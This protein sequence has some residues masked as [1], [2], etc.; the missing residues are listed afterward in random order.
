MS[1][2]PTFDDVFAVMAKAS[3]GDLTARVKV[4]DDARAD[5]V[6]TRFAIALNLLLEDLAFRTA[7]AESAHEAAQ[8][9]LE[10][11]VSERTIELATVNQK[12]SEA[13]RRKSEFL[14]SMSHEL[15]TPLN[16]ILGFADLL[17]ERLVG[18]LDERER[19]YLCNIRDAGR[20]LLGLINDVLD[21]SKVE[22]G[23]VELRPERASLEIIVA[24]LVSSTHADAE[25]SGV[26]FRAEIEGAVEIAADIGRVRQIL[27]NLL[28]N[29]VKFTPRGGEVTLQ[30]GRAGRDLVIR[31]SDTG[32]GIPAAKRQQVF[33]TFERLH[34]GLSDAPGT[35]LGL[36]L[37]KSLVELHGG[38]ITFQST[39][40]K[41]TTFRVL[42]PELVAE[43]MPVDRPSEGK[44]VP[45]AAAA[46]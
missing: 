45:P 30:A 21:L 1:R 12:L 23:R 17:E 34:E 10:G 19:R 39:E 7:E 2:S 28:S 14:A 31:V 13:S 41:G 37:T 5:D 9:E 6:A 26:K 25:S 11:K 22:A 16:A 42:L 40:G 3:V 32:I 15:R 36:A 20:H 18:S 35:G 33:G 29:A 27:Y 46:R 38:A 43:T 24:P 44:E 4:P 8:S